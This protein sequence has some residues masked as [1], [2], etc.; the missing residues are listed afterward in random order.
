[1]P[2]KTAS[3]A[4]RAEWVKRPAFGRFASGCPMGKAAHPAIATSPLIPPDRENSTRFHRI[5]HRTVAAPG[6]MLRVQS[7]LSVP[8]TKSRLPLRDLSPHLNSTHEPAP[9]PR[10]CAYSTRFRIHISLPLEQPAP[11]RAPKPNLHPTPTPNPQLP[12]TSASSATR[13]QGRPHPK[14]L[15]FPSQVL[16]IIIFKPN[17]RRHE[18]REPM[19]KPNS[20][21]APLSHCLIA[22]LVGR[23]S[24][25]H[26]VIPAHPLNVGFPR[27]YLK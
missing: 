5:P 19:P 21:F 18:H 1:M 17:P 20:P 13:T 26:C 12:K 25:W 10:N 2:R 14:M 6:G 4:G 24:L 8:T 15:T 11:C 16:E 3:Q 22:S 7:I 9:N 23:C 27:K